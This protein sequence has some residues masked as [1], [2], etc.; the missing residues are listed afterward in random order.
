WSTGE[1][2]TCVGTDTSFGI[3]DGRLYYSLGARHLELSGW[4]VEL[5]DIMFGKQNIPR[6]AARSGIIDPEGRIRVGVRSSNPGERL[7]E[8][9]KGQLTITF[10]ANSGVFAPLF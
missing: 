6:A 2:T 10:E 7:H 3:F 8:M 4:D 5:I 9:F 1:P